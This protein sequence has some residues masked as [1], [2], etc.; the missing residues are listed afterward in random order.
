MV[1]CHLRIMTILPLLVQFGY[2]LFLFLDGRTHVIFEMNLWILQVFFQENYERI[3]L[4]F[5]I[6]LVHL[7]ITFIVTLKTLVLMQL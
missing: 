1:S 5:L 3:F 6:I 2:N 4:S 7:S